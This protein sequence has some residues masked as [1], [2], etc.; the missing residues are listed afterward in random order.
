MQAVF[1]KED[2]TKALGV[3]LGVVE[4]KQTIDWNER[5]KELRELCNRFRKDNRNYDCL[6]P[7]SCF[8]KDH[9]IWKKNGLEMDV[10][11]KT[12]L[13]S[14]I[15]KHLVYREIKGL[16]C[17]IKSLNIE[18]NGRESSNTKFFEVPNKFAFSYD[19]SLINLVKQF[20]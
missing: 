19:T 6:V 17:I 8:S 2:I 14:S 18:A 13:P 5:E 10:V 4:K 11:Y 3:T 12:S 20:Q 7:I 9:N 15:N 1:K 16:G